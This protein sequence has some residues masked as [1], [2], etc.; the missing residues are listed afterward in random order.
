LQPDALSKRYGFPAEWDVRLAYNH[1]SGGGKF[2]ITSD[3]TGK[4][5]K[6]MKGI[7][8]LDVLSRLDTVFS[9]NAPTHFFGRGSQA[10]AYT[11]AILKVI[12]PGTSLT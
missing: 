1:K 12:G 11:E 6:S 10:R 3:A 9:A 2:D 5:V 4:V 7:H 8:S